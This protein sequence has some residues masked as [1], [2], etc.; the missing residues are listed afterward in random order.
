M[1][2]SGILSPKWDV[3]IKFL[4]SKLKEFCGREDGHIVRASRDSKHQEKR[5][6]LDTRGLTYMW[7]HR[8]YGTL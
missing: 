5:G 7:T 2:N 1:R 6:L 3:F 4:P 8:D